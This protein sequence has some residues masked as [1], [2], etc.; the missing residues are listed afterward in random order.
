M[1]ISTKIRYGTRAMLELAS[2]YGE[3][4]IDLREISEKE[5]IPLKY[6]EQVFIPLRVAGLVKSIR[7]AK[8]GY[9]LGR[10]PSEIHLSDLV[11]A[12][13]GPIRLIEC[14]HDQKFCKKY[15]ICVMREVWKEVSDSIERIL[16]SLTLEDLVN[17]KIEKDNFIDYLYQI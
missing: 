1:K 16:R 9:I 2:R 3:G 5:S 4:P 10:S 12:L 11:E 7:G 6:L 13:D 14:L 15:S 8:G 17:R